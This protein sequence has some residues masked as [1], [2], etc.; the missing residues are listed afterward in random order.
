LIGEPIPSYLFGKS[1][2]NLLF[3]P[4]GFESP[5]H[6]EI[7]TETG[8]ELSLKAVI[9][10]N[11]KL[12]RKKGIESDKP[13]KYELFNLMDDP[14]EKNNLFYRNPI[15]SEYLKRRMQNWAQ[16]QEKLAKLVKGDV[17]KILTKKEI[18]E[19]KALGYIQ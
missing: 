5:F 3:S 15:A 7:F 14:Y 6:D 2:K 1:L 11:W 4:P 17:E 16:S 19:L 18:E 12:I 8:K 10:G 13:E 9:D